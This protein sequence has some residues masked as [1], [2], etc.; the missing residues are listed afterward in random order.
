[1]KAHRL[2]T[3]IA[4]I[5]ISLTS[6]GQKIKVDAGK[7][8]AL[9]GVTDLRIEY[10]YSDLGV[11]K[12][13]VEA[14]YIDYKVAKMNKSEAG[15]GD[16]WKEAWFD[17]RPTRYEPKFEELFSEY[18]SFITSGQEIESDV[19]MLVHTSFIEPGY[20]VGVSRK[21]ASINLEISFMKGSEELVHILIIKSPGGGAMGYD[22]DTGYRIQESYAKAAKSLGKYLTKALK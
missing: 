13:E 17:D 7:L 21:S 15:T 14:E 2:L 1:M 16:S 12:Y 4:L 3:L 18:A 8:S 10:D 19:V 9:E 5:L 11:G 6:F 20:N 22:F